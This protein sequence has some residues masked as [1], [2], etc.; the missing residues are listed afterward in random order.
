M[1]GSPNDNEGWDLSTIFWLVV[2][3]AFVIGAL[4]LVGLMVKPKLEELFTPTPEPGTSQIFPVRHDPD[5]ECSD[6]AIQLY[7]PTSE[8]NVISALNNL[9]TSGALPGALDLE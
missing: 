2:M 5:F 3:A 4:V 7:A 8:S 1:S 6:L 9:D